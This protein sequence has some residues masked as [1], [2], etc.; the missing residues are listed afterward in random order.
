MTF[1]NMFPWRH[2]DLNP[3]SPTYNV[4][5]QMQFY[6]AQLLQI[7]IP[8]LMTHSRIEVA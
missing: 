7:V 6:N 5:K 4:P 3:P 8:L 2:P 1:P